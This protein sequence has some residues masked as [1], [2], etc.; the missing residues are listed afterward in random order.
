MEFNFHT[1]IVEIF[2]DSRRSLQAPK[3]EFRGH[4]SVLRVP[5]IKIGTIVATSGDLLNRLEHLNPLSGLPVVLYK[6]YAEAVRP[7]GGTALGLLSALLFITRAARD[8]GYDLRQVASELE[9]PST[10]SLPYTKSI[11]CKRS[12]AQITSY[13]TNRIAFVTH[14]GVVGISYHPDPLDGIRPGDRIVDLFGMNMPFVLREN[15]QDLTWQMINVAGVVGETMWYTT[16][17]GRERA[18]VH[19]CV[20][21][22]DVVSTCVSNGLEHET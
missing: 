19:Y 6:I 15:Y 16:K 7:H 21:I 22:N 1:D 12:S 18:G 20:G 9:T 14:K 13:A 8:R 5:G 4:P 3:I 17:D 2:E 10:T 11:D